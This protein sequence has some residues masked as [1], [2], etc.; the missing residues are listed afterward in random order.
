MTCRGGQNLYILSVFY[1]KMTGCYPYSN[2]KAACKGGFLDSRDRVRRA[3]SSTLKQTS[4]AHRLERE[5]AGLVGLLEQNAET[6]RDGSL[7][8][9]RIEPLQGQQLGRIA[10]LDEF[11][12]EA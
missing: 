1:R 5:L 12:P 9:G 7:N 11:V 8:T 2:K 10:M 4:S 3:H 6:R